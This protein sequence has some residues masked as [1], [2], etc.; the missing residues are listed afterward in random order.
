MTSPTFLILPQDAMPAVVPPATIFFPPYSGQAS[1]LE[2]FDCLLLAAL[3]QFKTTVFVSAAPYGS[4][5]VRSR[6]R[7]SFVAKFHEEMST[8]TRRSHWALLLFF[9]MVSISGRLA[10]AEMKK[11]KDDDLLFPVQTSVP[12]SWKRESISTRI[13]DA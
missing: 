13:G 2:R 12:R 3:G 4:Q 7:S 6:R 9:S 5:P 1:G 8:V 10:I 11:E